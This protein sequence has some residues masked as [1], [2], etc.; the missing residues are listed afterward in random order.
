MLH[1]IHP[2]LVHFGV[3]FV[4]TGA[5]AEAYAA[6][7]GNEAARRFGSPLLGAGTLA[8]IPTVASGY[9]A[10]NTIELPAGAAATLADHER[11]GWVLLAG[12]VLMQFWKAWHG[13]RLP[14]V[15]RRFYALALVA[16]VAWLAYSAFLGG[17]LVY[18]FGVG[19]G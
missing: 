4:A 8:L 1:L 14:A 13:G 19:I 18:T 9:L 7:A 10:A 17:R 16:L 12:L 11:N 3:A 6:V 5:L 15:Q 2:A